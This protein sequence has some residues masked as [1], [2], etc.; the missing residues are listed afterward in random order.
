ML[1]GTLRFFEDMGIVDADGEYPSDWRERD[2]KYIKETGNIIDAV[3]TV[4]IHIKNEALREI[5]C[6][7]MRTHYEAPK[8]MAKKLNAVKEVANFKMNINELIE[9]LQLFANLEDEYWVEFH[10]HTKKYEDGDSYLLHIEGND[11]AMYLTTGVN[12]L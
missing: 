1:R 6:K 5:L 11:I 12:K 3:H 9:A 7:Y 10:I 8:D 2:C 4:M